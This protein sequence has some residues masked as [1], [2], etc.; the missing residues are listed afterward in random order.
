MNKEE[1]HK[2]IEENKE[3]IEES[4]R[5]YLIKQIKDLNLKP[6]KFCYENFGTACGIVDFKKYKYL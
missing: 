4:R 1:L 6:V 3:D 2:F 5:Q